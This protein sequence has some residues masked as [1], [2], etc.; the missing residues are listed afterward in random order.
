M[1]RRMVLAISRALEWEGPRAAFL[2]SALRV[3]GE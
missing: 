1:Q 3:S 2:K